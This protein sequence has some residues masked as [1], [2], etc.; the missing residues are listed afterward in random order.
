[1]III[2]AQHKFK[3]LTHLSEETIKNI[4]KDSVLSL[5]LDEIEGPFCHEKGFGPHGSYLRKVIVKDKTYT[6]LIDRVICVHCSRT[7]TLIPDFILPFLYRIVSHVVD[8]FIEI[9]LSLPSKRNRFYYLY[10]LPL[11]LLH[12]RNLACLI[13]IPHEINGYVYDNWFVL[14]ENECNLAY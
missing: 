7:H 12:K 6:F 1:M 8:M 3:Q 4:Y 13:Q 10:Y 5:N 9:P 14:Q 2:H 11:L